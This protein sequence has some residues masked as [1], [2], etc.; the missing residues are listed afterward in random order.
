MARHA[1]ACACVGTANAPSNHARVAVE[2]PSSAAALLTGSALP[3]ARCRSAAPSFSCHLPSLPPPTDIP[4]R[5][6]V[7]PGRHYDGRAGYVSPVVGARAAGSGGGRGQSPA[8]PPWARS[9]CHAPCQAVPA[10]STPA[11]PD[12]TAKAAREP[13]QRRPAPRPPPPAPAG[14]HVAP[15]DQAAGATPTAADPGGPVTPAGPAAPAALPVAPPGAATLPQ[16]SA[17]PRTDDA[18]FNNAVHDIWLAVTTGN[19]NYALPAFFPEKAYEQV[20][21]IADPAADW[22]GRLWYDF[23][24]DLAAAHKLVKPGAMLTKV[25][26]PAQYAQWIPPGACY[27]STGYWHLPGSRVV[28]RAGRSHALVRDSFVD[29]LARRLV[30]GPLRRGGARRRL[31]HRRRPGDGRRVSPG[32]PAAASVSRAALAAAP[33][34]D[35]VRSARSRRAPRRSR[36]ASPPA[37]RPRPGTR[38]WT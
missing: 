31:R 35:P 17:L 12:S 34:T 8:L 7:P 23:T 26:V 27:N 15:D 28:Y 18:A 21:A 24:L 5:Q 9:R 30:P 13:G 22:Q 16:T 2:N 20:K 14:N 4:V 19:P 25:I 11:R 38:R 37:T 6:E 29:L 33:R 1:C 32:R 3:P 36:S 10:A